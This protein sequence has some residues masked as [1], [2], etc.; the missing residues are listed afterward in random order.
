L[1][2]N[3]LQLLKT[4]TDEMKKFPLFTLFAAL[5]LAASA[6]TKEAAEFNNISTPRTNPVPDELVGRWAIIGISGS[7][8]YDIP[9]GYTSNTSEWFLGYEI[10]KDGTVREDG[11]LATYQY[12]VSTWAK[13]TTYG[14][15][16][17]DGGGMAFYRDHGSYTSSRSATPKNFGKDEVYPNKSDV[18]AS[19]EVG[20]DSQGRPALLLT[21]AD[22]HV[23]TF[24][25]Q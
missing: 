4:K 6:C 24:V 1:P 21:S 23:H 8:V 7:T 2:P 20:T 3:K 14:S 13:W 9:S 25:K 10:K 12:G 17:I 15:V 22:G 11:Y 16:K 18:Y 5:L 19:F